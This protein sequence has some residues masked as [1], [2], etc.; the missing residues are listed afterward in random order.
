MTRSDAID[1]AINYLNAVKNS[2]GNYIF[3]DEGACAFSVCD[4]YD[5]VELG[6][7]LDAGTPDAYSHWCAGLSGG[8]ATLDEM[9]AK[10]VSFEIVELD[11]STVDREGELVELDREDFDWCR[12]VCA[13]IKVGLVSAA[14]TH[15]RT[16]TISAAWLGVRPSDEEQARRTDP[17][18]FAR[19]WCEDET[20]S[21]SAWADRLEVLD[22]LDARKVFDAA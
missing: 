20:R 22:L 16:V 13:E 14:F 4:E 21:D 5:M 11:Q 12:P 8:P 7:A 10:V 3:H 15:E 2:A 19:L 6:E 17:R 1:T 9:D 18:A